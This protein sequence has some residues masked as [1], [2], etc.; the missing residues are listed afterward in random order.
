MS[1]S[2]H[3]GIIKGLLYPGL[4]DS[5][6]LEDSQLDTDFFEEDY[7]MAMSTMEQQR[8]EVQTQHSSV[9]RVS[10]Q[11]ESNVD[12]Y[13]PDLRSSNQSN[14]YQSSYFAAMGRPYSD[15]S[16]QKLPPR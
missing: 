15:L 3:D 11:N 7:E 9:P 13:N 4:E 6:M 12:R 16:N 5:Q 2:E 10:P 14:S 8:Q 1:N